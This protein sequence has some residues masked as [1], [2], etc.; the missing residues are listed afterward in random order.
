MISSHMAHNPVP[1]E[2]LGPLVEEA[3]DTLRSLDSMDVPNSLRHIHGFDRRALLAGP[4]RRQLLRTLRNG[5]GFWE[6]VAERFA[7]RDEVRATLDAWSVA[8]AVACIDAVHARR[9]LPL[10]ASAL[11]AMQPEGAE[12]GLGLIAARAAD[13]R[14]ER[15]AAS[16][17]RAQDRELAEVEEARRRADVARMEA[18]ADVARATSELQ[19]ERGAR[20]SR[21]ERAVADAKSARSDVERLELEL[22]D[23]AGLLDEE[24][25]RT[26]RERK[27]A[28]ALEEDVK[29][30]RTELEDTQRQSHELRLEPNDA[31]AV[32]N[33]AA[34]AERAPASLRATERRLRA[35]TAGSPVQ[36]SRAPARAREVARRVPSAPSGRCA[37]DLPRGLASDS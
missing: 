11:W 37:P 18:E 6:P 36:G 28:R 7:A 9:D 15:G 21:E 31:Q 8:D 1:D 35:E 23:A 3:A 29:R 20:R 22:K 19:K 4:G 34:A 25:L 24:R 13:A 27:R 17:S 26:E 33:A 30:L 14:A 12:F 10:L 5:G 2:P 16:A 32:T